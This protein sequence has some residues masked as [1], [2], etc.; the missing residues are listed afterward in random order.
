[1][2]RLL[3]FAVVLALC[4]TGARADL[5]E[6]CGQEDVEIAIR[7]CTQIIALGQKLPNLRPTPSRCSPI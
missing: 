5:Y 6:D 3:V 1:M 4:A 2:E 7:G